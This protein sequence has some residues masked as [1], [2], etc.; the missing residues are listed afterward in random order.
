M[1]DKIRIIKETITASPR[2]LTEKWTYEHIP[3]RTS[4]IKPIKDMTKEEEA[5]EIIR[6]LSAPPRPKKFG[7]NWTT[8]DINAIHGIDLEKEIME[9][10]S[11]SVAEEIDKELLA[12]LRNG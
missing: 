12:K 6:R 2:K 1:T 4:R 10:L 9:A 3:D 5:D 7:A 8:Q 11:A